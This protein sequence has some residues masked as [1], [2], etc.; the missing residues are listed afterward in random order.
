[1]SQR[2]GVSLPS[3]ALVKLALCRWQ[4]PLYAMY[5]VLLVAWACSS[6]LLVL[7]LD[8]RAW[9]AIPSG[10]IGVVVFLA[11]GGVAYFRMLQ[12][13]SV[14]L[15][16]RTALGR[17]LCRGFLALGFQMTKR[18]ATL[19][20]AAQE[21]AATLERE[22]PRPGSVC[23][24]G[25]STFTFWQHLRDDIEALIPGTV[26]FNAGFGGSRTQDVVNHAHD[27][28]IKWSPAV[29]VYFCGTNNLATGMRRSTL[30]SGFKQFVQ[31]LRQELPDTPVV[32]LAPNVTPFV[33]SRPVFA[34]QYR[35]ACQELERVCVDMDR[36]AY[37]DLTR[38]EFAKDACFYLADGHHL[39]EE[40]HRRLAKVLAPHIK[41]ALNPTH[42]TSTS[43]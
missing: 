13:D 36:C 11:A 33:A 18:S 16:F 31:L 42:K 6:S 4:D 27:L 29:V 21:K 30:V 17:A 5:G 7:A 8:V 37:V 25:S 9:L 1:M 15:C 3:R 24:V 43:L 39:T 28:C 26:A 32:Y 41:A 38:Q 12:N 10:L 14:P 22:Q 19:D 40:G 2:N 20:S 34:D 35:A 23:F